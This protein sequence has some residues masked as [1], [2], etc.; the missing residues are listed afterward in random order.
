LCIDDSPIL[1]IFKQITHLEVIA[2]E[3]GNTISQFNLNK[4]AYE[5]LFSV[6]QRLTHLNIDAKCYRRQQ[7]AFPLA[8]CSSSILIELHVNVNTI[9]DC[10]RLLDGRFSE[11]KSFSVKIQFGGSSNNINNTVNNLSIK[12]LLFNMFFHYFLEYFT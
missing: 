8:N 6:C 9:D 7:Y 11:M 10:L 4:N 1:R 12:M 2:I 3:Y 5:R